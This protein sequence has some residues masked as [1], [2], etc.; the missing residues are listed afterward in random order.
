MNYYLSILRK[1]QQRAALCILGTFCI[2]PISG[3]KAISSLIPVYLYLK[4][5]YRRFLLRGSSL[6][7]NHIISSILNSNGL[8]DYNHH[9]ISIDHL[10]SKQRLCL[11]S[12]LID[13][14]NRCNELFPSFLFFND[15][16]K[17]GNYLIDLFSDCFSFH[18]HS[19]NTNKHIEKLDDIVFRALSNSFSSIV[20]SDTSI[21]NYVATSISHIHSYDKPVI[22]MIHKAVNI[23]TTEAELFAIQCS[24]NQVVSITN[25]NYIVVITN[26]LH[27]AK[28]IFDS[29]SHPY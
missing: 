26:F 14:N 27:T 15:E 18:S 21:K 11:K 7:S 1:I 12:T 8:Y 24:I 17:P 25:V 13:V 20:V 28:R 4:K 10:T 23:T 2:F 9:S 16:F 5:L 29:L 6:F 22:K 19:S 3:I